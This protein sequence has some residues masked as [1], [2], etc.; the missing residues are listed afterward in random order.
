ML[1]VSRTRGF[2]SRFDQGSAVVGATLTPLMVGDRPMGSRDLRRV[3]LDEAEIG[4][5]CWI[6]SGQTLP[7]SCWRDQD[8]RCGFRRSWRCS[9]SG[10]LA[11]CS[12][13][14]WA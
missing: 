14:P 10:S 13:W 1:P 11:L 3:E 9:C 12:G 2:S 6:S 4:T 5:R 7:C 8:V